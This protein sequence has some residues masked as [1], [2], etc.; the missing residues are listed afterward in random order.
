MSGKMQHMSLSGIVSHTL[1]VPSMHGNPKGFKSPVYRM[2]RVKGCAHAV[3]WGRPR[4]RRRRLLAMG[5]GRHEVHEASRS[6][7]GHWRMSNNKLVNRALT[8]EWLAAQG[9]PSLEEQWVSIALAS[10]RPFGQ[11]FGWLPCSAVFVIT[12]DQ[13]ELSRGNS[14]RVGTAVL[15]RLSL[16]D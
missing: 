9:V 11:P 4:T 7:K 16:L 2:N 14:W 5:I 6:R 12:T 1:C 15:P 3:A 13:R 8:N 10:P